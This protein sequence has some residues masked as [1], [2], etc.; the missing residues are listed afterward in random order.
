MP[1][2]IPEG[3]MVEVSW[4]QWMNGGSPLRESEKAFQVGGTVFA[5]AQRSE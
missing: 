3:F 4:A 1:T 5:K 2:E